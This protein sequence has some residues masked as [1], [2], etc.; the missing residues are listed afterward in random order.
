M[1]VPHRTLWILLLKWLKFISLRAQICYRL[2]YNIHLN[3]CANRKEL[4]LRWSTSSHIPHE[5]KRARAREKARGREQR[6]WVVLFHP[7]W[8]WQAM[9]TARRNVSFTTALSSPKSLNLLLLF[10]VFRFHLHSKRIPFLSS[11]LHHFT[12]H[13]CFLWRWYMVNMPKR[14]FVFTTFL[15]GIP[16]FRIRRDGAGGMEASES[17]FSNFRANNW[18]GKRTLWFRFSSE[19]FTLRSALRAALN[20][21]QTPYFKK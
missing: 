3:K 17:F 15:K 8:R 11:F 1:F 7:V 6:C 19:K 2:Y 16:S 4:T 5:I 21:H 10:L 18:R 13:N 14:N 20:K 12:P 9:T